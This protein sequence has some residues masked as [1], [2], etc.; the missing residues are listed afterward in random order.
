MTPWLSVL[1]LGEEGVESLAPAARALLDAAEVLVGGERHLAMVKNG[2]AER[3]AWASPLS[4]TLEDIAAR[5]GKRVAVL[6]TGDPMFYGIGVTLARRFPW[7]EISVIPAVGAMAHVCARLG[8][9]EAEVEG[10]T[11]HGRPLELLNYHML[12]HARLVILSED[13][14]TPGK[15]AE[16]LAASGFGSSPIVVF[17]HLGGTEERRIEATAQDFPSGGCADLNTMAVECRAAAGAVFNPRVP[18]LPDIAFENDG[19]LTKREVRAATLAALAPTPGALLWDVGAGSGSIA[20]EWLRAERTA[21][22]IAVECRPERAARIARNALA[23]G[24]P[25]LEIVAGEAP[26]ALT[27]LRA[28]DAVFVGGA[29]RN[30]DLLEACFAAIKD[31][32]RFVANAVTLEG[33][34][35]LIRLRE[36]HGGEMTRLSVSRLEPVG[37]GQGWRALRPVTQLSVTKAA[38]HERHPLRRGRRPRRSR[39]GDA[40]GGPRPA[41]LPGHCLSRVSRRP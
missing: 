18:G 4:Q 7:G 19:Q 8:W 12:P 38:G 10:V 17:E 34:A 33:E 15:V 25:R 2:G 22:A 35:A 30:A 31:G 1:G 39:A 41:R 23:L 40:E 5:R 36:R 11:L 3:I 29:V 26:E 14:T 24:V 20:I 13:G 16:A 21:Q 32:G 27:G 37:T 28:P 9:A 6:A